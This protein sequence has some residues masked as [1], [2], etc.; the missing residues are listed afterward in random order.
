[1]FYFYFILKLANT[2]PTIQLNKPNYQVDT[3][4]L[5]PIQIIANI[6]DTNNPKNLISI[7]LSISNASNYTVLNLPS[8]PVFN[9]TITILYN[10]KINEYPIF[11]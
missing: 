7:S 6:F 8:N 5:N 11:K 4:Q 3:A 1:M 9:A 10:P 2:P